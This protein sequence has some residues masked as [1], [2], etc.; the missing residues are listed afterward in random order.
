MT[1]RK[2]LERL[3]ARHG[4][5]GETPTVTRIILRA[6]RREDGT[7]VSEAMYAWAKARDGWETIERGDGEPEAAFLERIDVLAESFLA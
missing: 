3:E 6:V 7:T 2:R 5:G 4:A 1:L